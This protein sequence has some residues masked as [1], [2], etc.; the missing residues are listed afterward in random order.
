[1]LIFKKESLALLHYDHDFDIMASNMT[2][3][4]ILNAL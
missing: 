3:I 1:M 4:R 2:V